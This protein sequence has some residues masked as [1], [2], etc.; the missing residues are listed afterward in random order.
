MRRA[1]F[2]MQTLSAYGVSTLALPVYEVCTPVVN[3]TRFRAKCAHPH[4]R[5]ED[6]DDEGGHMMGVYCLEAT[7]FGMLL[8]IFSGYPMPFCLAKRPQ[9]RSDLSIEDVAVELPRTID[10]L[11]YEDLPVPFSTLGRLA[12]RRDG[13]A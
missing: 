8:G 11:D 2:D 12:L 7:L 13:P 5:R 1:L 9:P 4:H 6:G 10:L 3:L